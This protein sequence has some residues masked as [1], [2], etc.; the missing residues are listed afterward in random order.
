[1][2]SNSNFIWDILSPQSWPSHPSIRIS[3]V[4]IAKGT[5]QFRGAES[6]GS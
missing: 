2:N 3:G 1:M 4:K 5:L 6:M